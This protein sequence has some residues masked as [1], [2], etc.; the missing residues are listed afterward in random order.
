MA[1]TQMKYESLEAWEAKALKEGCEITKNNKTAVYS[2]FIGSEWKGFYSCEDAQGVLTVAS[3]KY[4][5]TLFGLEIDSLGGL[6]DV[7]CT[8]GDGQE[9]REDARKRVE[10]TTPSLG[11]F[12]AYENYLTSRFGEP[13][14][15]DSGEVAYCE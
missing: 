7:L 1:N 11:C 2:A 5:L 8:I 15:K 4:S 13:D 6:L 14:R 3:P 12:L 10:A 9:E